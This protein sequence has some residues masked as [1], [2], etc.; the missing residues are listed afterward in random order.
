MISSS[1]VDDRCSGSDD[2]AIV[3]YCFH[4]LCGGS[5]TCMVYVACGQPSNDEEHF[6]GLWSE[7]IES[8]GDSRQWKHPRH[9]IEYQFEDAS[10]CSDR[11][12]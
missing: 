12:T 9:H 5:F 6:F 10:V 11:Y 8:S 7:M 1:A 2:G 4:N 3:V